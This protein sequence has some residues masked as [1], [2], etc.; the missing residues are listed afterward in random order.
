[1]ELRHLITF[2]AIY[3]YGGF[4]KAAEHLG[5]AQSTVTSH[6]QSLES[7]IGV[8]VFDRLGKS[9]I[10][11]QT[12]EQLMPYAI[13]ML[14]LY[15]NAKNIAA[16]SEHPTGTLT[17]AAPES[18][19]SYCLPAIVKEFVQSY[20]K[21]DLILRPSHSNSEALRQLRSGDLDMVYMLDRMLEEQDLHIENISHEPLALIAPPTFRACSWS[22]LVEAIPSSTF[23]FTQSGCVYRDL[24]ESYL[25]E[26]RISPKASLD[27]WSVEAMK[28]SVMCGL[29]LSILPYFAVSSEISE[30][31]LTGVVWEQDVELKTQLVFHKNKWQSAAFKRFLEL[32]R[33]RASQWG[34]QEHKQD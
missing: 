5:Y 33:K 23:L 18:L 28:Q 12:G 14:K 25:Q 26:L 17:I 7:E 15:T 10:L 13:E 30:G 32:V 31:K 24:F 9:V 16:S 8:P 4:T 19:T 3:D 20:P 29:G 11:T 22:Q 27:F 2:K 34:N 1:M 21:V 6:I